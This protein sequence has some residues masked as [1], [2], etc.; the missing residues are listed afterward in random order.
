MRTILSLL[1]ITIGIFT[2]I[3]VFSAVDSFRN[4][5]QASVDKLGSNTLFVQKWPWVFGGDYPWWKYVNR[6]QPSERD[7]ADLKERLQNADGI[8]YQ[9][10]TNSRTVKYRS[11]SVEGIGHRCCFARL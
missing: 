5:L 11:S 1:A 2:I 6:P 3:A 9:I 8:T 7:F 4:K 10:S